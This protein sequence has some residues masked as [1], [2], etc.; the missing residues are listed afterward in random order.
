[1]SAFIIELTETDANELEVL[2]NWCSRRATIVRRRRRDQSDPG[3]AG[4][5]IAPRRS[6][7]YIAPLVPPRRTTASPQPAAPAGRRHHEP[8]PMTEDRDYLQQPDCDGL[9]ATIA[10][11][12]RSN[13]ALETSSM[14]PWR[15]STDQ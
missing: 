7:S 12:R 6:P 14:C 1:V 11:L 8:Q 4:P 15:P 13:T 10:P 5:L 2:Y 9:S 3:P